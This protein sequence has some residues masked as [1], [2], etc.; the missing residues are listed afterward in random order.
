MNYEQD[1]QIDPT[2]LD[3]EWVQ[4][5]SLVLKYNR[6]VTEWERTVE[7]SKRNLDVITAEL[8]S[9]IRKN[10]DKYGL[11]KVTETGVAW[12]VKVQP[13]YEEA[14][15]EYLEARYEASMAQAASRALQDKRSALEN[16]VRLHGQNYFAGPNLPREIDQEWGKKQA[17]KVSNDVVGRRLTRGIRKED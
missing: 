9:K 10:P 2:A 15:T 17:Q 14:Y 8:D 13:E 3:V 11:D 5:A 1:I 4:Q 12:A 6:L 7:R 16:L